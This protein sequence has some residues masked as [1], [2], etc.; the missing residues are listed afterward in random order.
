MGKLTVKE[1]TE[2]RESGVLSLK[3]LNEMQEKGLVSQKR[4]S[5]RR[6]MKT[7]EGNLVSPQLYFQGIG[8]DSYSEKM[9]ELKAQFNSI[10]NN[11]TSKTKKI[12]KG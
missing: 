9:T 8:K 12:N 10:L 4:H 1:A 5:T 6:Y 2:L 7:N 3:A 11:Y